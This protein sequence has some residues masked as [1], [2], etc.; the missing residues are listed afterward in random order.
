VIG[1]NLMDFLGVICW[2]ANPISNQLENVFHERLFKVYKQR[3][4]KT[5]WFRLVVVIRDKATVQNQV[6]ENL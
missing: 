2:V 4:G 6:N 3:L 1:R 5:Q